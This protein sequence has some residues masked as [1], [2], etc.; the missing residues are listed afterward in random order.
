MTTRGEQNIPGALDAIRELE[1]ALSDRVKHRAFAA[2][3]R[4]AARREADGLIAEANER[5]ARAAERA[6]Q[7]V[8]LASDIEIESIRA[9]ADDEI[10]LLHMRVT[11]MRAELLAGMRAVA[12]P[13]APDRE[14]A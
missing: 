6:R 11:T 9:G 10:A 8:R 2:E 12:L 4:Q 5:G 3:S 14:D 13:E 7:K 1:R